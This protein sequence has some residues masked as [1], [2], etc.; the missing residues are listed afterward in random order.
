MPNSEI[1]LARHGETEWS[2]SGQHTGLTDIPLTDPGRR[3]AEA[4]GERL[5]DHTVE[6]VLT[7]PLS[8][9]SETCRIAGFGDRCAERS[10]LVEWRYGDYEGLTTAQIRESDPGW[11]VWTHP[12]PG[13]ETPAE[14]GARVDAVIEELAESEADAAVFAH[15]HVLRVLGAR[16]IGL[17]AEGGAMLA[18]SPATLSILGWERERR[19]IKLWNDASH[20]AGV[21]G[22]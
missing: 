8:R 22:A 9:A 3:Q 17:A 14:V 18:L 16:W 4:L 21:P 2:V 6:T 5:R 11:T 10:E 13:A 12:T 15:G 19:V 1:L 7:S 20:L